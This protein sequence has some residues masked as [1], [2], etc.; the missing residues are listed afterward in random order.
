MHLKKEEER[1]RKRKNT[2]FLWKFAHSLGAAS[3]SLKILIHFQIKNVCCII[4]GQ[5]HVV[6]VGGFCQN[7]YCVSWKQGETTT[8]INK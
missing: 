3:F 5:G 7:Y 1:R 8:Q 4:C 6:K 2:V